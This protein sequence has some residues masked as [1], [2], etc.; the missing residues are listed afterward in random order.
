MTPEKKIWR[1][2]EETL[3][4]AMRPALIARDREKHKCHVC[5]GL[6]YW[7]RGRLPFRRVAGMLLV[8]SVFVIPTFLAIMALLGMDF[9]RVR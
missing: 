2:I 8:S 4:R 6:G 9:C 7:P 5:D 1:E 3:R